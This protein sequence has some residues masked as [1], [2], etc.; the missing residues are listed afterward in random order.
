[1]LSDMTL[2]KRFNLSLSRIGRAL[3]TLIPNSRRIVII[4]PYSFKEPTLYSVLFGVSI[5]FGQIDLLGNIA[6]LREIK[7][8]PQERQSSV[9]SL[10]YSTKI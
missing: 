6:V 8:W 5:N 10:N 2:P 3:I 1:M 4:T 9:L 7:P